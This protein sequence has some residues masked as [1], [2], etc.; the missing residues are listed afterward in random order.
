M[1]KLQKLLVMLRLALDWA[2]DLEKEAAILG[3]NGWDDGHQ[4]PHDRP[5]FLSPFQ[6][7]YG[8][9]GDWN[10]RDERGASGAAG[11]RDADERKV[12]SLAE[13]GD[14]SRNREGNVDRG[15]IGD[16]PAAGQGHA[17]GDRSE[18]VELEG[19]KFD[20]GSPG[21]PGEPSQWVLHGRSGRASWLA[22]LLPS[23]TLDRLREENAKGSR[24][25]LKL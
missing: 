19:L 8:A 15:A 2:N 23:V 9:K 3:S 22:W 17:G 1:Q 12:L 16:L 13:I 24:W 18:A 10:E 11:N 25:L 7:L 21:L 5:V 20:K 4:P 14:R 6:V